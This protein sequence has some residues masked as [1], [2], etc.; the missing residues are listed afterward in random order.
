[1]GATR[2]R[3]TPVSAVPVE[4][5]TPTIPSVVAPTIVYKRTRTQDNNNNME[6][7]QRVIRLLRYYGIQMTQ[8]TVVDNETAEIEVGSHSDGVTAIK[9][10]R[11]MND[12]LVLLTWKPS[13]LEY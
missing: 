3:V 12:E 4:K 13:Y 7:F 11:R 9:S 1:M 2:T 6:T 5:V 10:I 8:V